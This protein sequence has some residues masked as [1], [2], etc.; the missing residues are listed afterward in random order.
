MIPALAHGT[1]PLRVFVPLPEK[2]GSRPVSAVNRTV[3]A[4]LPVSGRPAR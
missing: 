4:P 1:S 3:M 2:S